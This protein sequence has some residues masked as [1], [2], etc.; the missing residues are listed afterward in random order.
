MLYEPGLPDRYRRALTAVLGP[1]NN[2]LRTVDGAQDGKP[3]N[4]ALEAAATKADAAADS[5]DRAEIPDDAMTGNGQLAASLHALGQGMRSARGDGSCCATSPRVELGSA[6]DP[7]NAEEAG[8]A[9]TALRS[10][11]LRPK[12]LRP[13]QSPAVRRWWAAVRHSEGGSSVPS[14]PRSRL[15]SSIARS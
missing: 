2:A 1:L 11:E 10:A 9:L 6:E 4:I 5:L 14:G 15:R 8:R 12:P 7:K 3:L 13:P